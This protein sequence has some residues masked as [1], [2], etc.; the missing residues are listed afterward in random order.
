VYSDKRPSGVPWAGALFR[1][2]SA[3][4]GRHSVLVWRGMISIPKKTPPELFD[5]DNH[6]M[7][8]DVASGLFQQRHG[9]LA[10][11]T[12]RNNGGPPANTS[13]AGRG[14]EVANN[15]YSPTGWR[16]C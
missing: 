14:H 11:G 6:T 9:D 13:A 3:P 4:R 16:T 2:N 5:D 1:R 7:L 10:V 12:C 15:E 8:E